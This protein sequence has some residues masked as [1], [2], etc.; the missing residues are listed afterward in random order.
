MNTTKYIFF[1][2]LLVILTFGAFYSASSQN[3][4]GEKYKLGLSFEQNGDFVNAARIYRE[5]YDEN[6]TDEQYFDAYVRASRKQDKYSELVTFVEEHIKIMP[7]YD[8]YIL[9]GE[10]YWREGSTE[11]SESAWRKAID[12]APNSQMAYSNLASAQMMLRLFDK[13][14]NTYLLARENLNVKTIF[15]DQLSQLYS[16]SGNYQDGTKEVL[17]LFA[18]TNNIALVQGRLAALNVNKNAEDFIYKILEDKSSDPDINYKKIFAWFTSSIGK[19]GEALEIYKTIDN[20]SNARGAEVYNFALN[21]A[22]DAKFDIAVSAFQWII[23]KGKESPYTVTSL[24]RLAKTLEQKYETT[25]NLDNRTSEDIIKKYRS[26]IADYPNT[27]TAHDCMFN[28]ALLYI[29]M[30]QYD[31]AIPE[32]EPLTE[33]ANYSNLG[34]K[35]NLMLGD[36]YFLKDDLN[37]A[38]LTYTKNVTLFTKHRDEYFAAQ[39]ALAEIQYFRGNIDTAVAMFTEISKNT[40][41]DAAN[42]ALAKIA[43]I[44]GNKNMTRA[45]LL[46]A[47]GEKFEKQKKYYEALQKFTEA[48]GISAPE[49]IFDLSLIKSSAMYLELGNKAKAREVLE[50]ILSANPQSINADYCYFTI[51]RILFSENNFEE[52]IKQFTILLKEYPRSIHNEEARDIIRQMRAMVN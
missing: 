4:Y 12:A 41:S 11:K 40:G 25:G 23:G 18:Q 30:K 34:A 45:L 19:D 35:A 1:S 36:I 29:R 16:I 8:N 6:K 20:Q 21:A 28:I 14:T 46:F 2:S 44:N 7:T 24:F 42:D 10:L 5:L 37:A 15:A 27:S 51:G 43:L 50:Q 52:S 9:L 31:L 48:A 26:V 38:I 13:A 33:N 22:N 17:N 39:F 32:L 3:Y 49:N 47:E